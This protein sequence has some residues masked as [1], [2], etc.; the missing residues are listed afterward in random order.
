MNHTNHT[1]V[2]H[3][4]HQNP[5]I[6][7]PSRS[8]RPQ[9]QIRG[10]PNLNQMNQNFR[11][12]TSQQQ[13]NEM[14]MMLQQ[15]G[16]TNLANSSFVGSRALRAKLSQPKPGSL[17]Y[18][19]IQ[20]NFQESES[21]NDSNYSERLEHLEHLES[22][23]KYGPESL[24]INDLA[25]KAHSHMAYPNV[26]ASEPFFQLPQKNLIVD[27]DPNYLSIDSQDRDRTKYPNPNEYTIPLISSDTSGQGSVPG[28]RYKNIVE[29]QILSAV[30][31][32][33][34][35]VL[36]E[37]Y[38]ILEIDEIDNVVFDSSNHRLSR[39]FKLM[40]STCDGTSKWLRLD[41]DISAPLVKRFYPKPKASL[42][43]ITIR[44]L[45]RDGTPFNFGTDNSPP[46]EVNADLQNSWTFKITQRITDVEEAIG[47]RNI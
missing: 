7:P 25:Q 14:G 17:S 32:N 9:T 23:N 16:S 33:R 24:Q 42:D 31:P 5:N 3:D 26:Y 38:L 30:I 34:N 22:L 20:S 35:N 18:A 6:Y 1:N 15:N 45:R 10:D 8:Y 21:D 46:S 37:I 13:N 12:I 2:Y 29:I 11:N 27:P 44:L 39:G 4:V 47:Q 28:R 41:D 40:F 36:D 43:R 19:D